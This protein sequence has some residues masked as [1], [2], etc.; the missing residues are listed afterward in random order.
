MSNIVAQD[1]FDKDNAPGTNLTAHTPAPLNGFMSG[2]IQASSFSDFVIILSNGAKFNSGT[3]RNVS[4][5]KIDTGV[6]DN[7]QSWV[8][9]YYWDSQPYRMGIQ[10]G[11]DNASGVLGDR[12]LELQ[13]EVDTN[14]EHVYVT[15]VLDAGA[16]GGTVD[17]G[18]RY[19]DFGIG[20]SWGIRVGCTLVGAGGSG[21]YTLWIE[22]FAGGTRQVILTTSP[23]GVLTPT[24][25][26][27]DFDHSSVGL[28]YENSG[29]RVQNLEVWEDDPP[30]IS[31]D[32]PV[33][34]SGPQGPGPILHN[35]EV[36][37]TGEG[38]LSGIDFDTVTEDW[39]NP[40]FT[41][42]ENPWICQ[43]S[44]DTTG[45]TPGVYT[46]QFNITDP[47]ADNSPQTVTVQVTITA[48]PRISVTSP[49]TIYAHARATA[50]PAV[51]QNVLNIGQGSFADLAL[52]NLTYI[53]PGYDWFT[54]LLTGTLI[55]VIG[56]TE[57]VPEGTW[58][59]SFDVESSNADNSPQT[60]EVILIFGPCFDTDFTCT[61]EPVDVEVTDDCIPQW[62]PVGVVP[63]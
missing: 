39:L 40:S 26:G 4:L 60:V 33:T 31:V 48:I 13:F 47:T 7:F 51:E 1:I 3:P 18:H 46:A 14:D 6:F 22:P 55:S 28:H 53:E 42:D 21:T 62:I 44:I 52:T 17:V 19:T 29:T 30:H 11:L 57:N 9:L 25:N 15:P 41:D 56:N 12:W 34:L 27:L 63:T 20:P 45:M 36:Y 49:M 50:L 58:H 24:W 61:P 8:D 10:W 5:L 54:V 43:L 35:L 16:G 23:G 59:G 38:S 32:S 37:N 2:W